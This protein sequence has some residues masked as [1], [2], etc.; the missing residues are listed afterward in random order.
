[1][2]RLKTYFPDIVGLYIGSALSL[3]LSASCAAG[4]PI[5]TDVVRGEKSAAIDA[6]FSGFNEAT[7][8]CAVAVDYQG[9]IV[10]MDGYGM[11][12]L[13]QAVPIKS[14]SVFYAGSVSKQVVAMSVMLLDQ[15]GKVDLDAKL[16][17]YLAE[18]PD[19]ANQVTVRQV[20][21][22]TSGI[23]DFF[24]LLR[25]AG[26]FDGMVITENM[27]TEILARQEGLNFTPGEQYAYSNSAYFLISQIVQQVEGE[28]LDKFS[29][30]NI[31]KPLGMENSH[32]QHN[33]RRLVPNK[34]HGYM[35]SL[36][37]D[38]ESGYMQADATLD[39]VGSGGMYTTVYD[40]IL[41]DR[42]F[43][44]NVL[45]SGQDI[46]QEMQTSGV[47]NAGGETGYGIGLKLKPY[48]GLKQISH[49][50]S[51]AGYRARLQRFPDHKFTVAILCNTAAAKPTKL[52]NQITDIF[53]K[54]YLQAKKPQQKKKP[55]PSATAFQR[56]SYEHALYAGR[57]YSREVDN[58]ITLEIAEH[59]LHI[60]GMDG[61]HDRIL[62]SASDNVYRHP[63]KNFELV[64]ERQPDGKV[65]AFTFNGAR[66]AGIRFT[67]LH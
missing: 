57:Y 29:Q 30:E 11:A 28:N 38:L 5:A 16:S 67:K 23:R 19:Y 24:E 34:A 10:H 20:L 53:L 49:S 48:R 42:N 2:K 62:Y 43:Y 63:I 52:A 27:I 22:H 65:L 41:W 33:H 1:M 58:T 32:F 56:S 66:A 51:L 8:G 54:E 26:R 61:L 64:F 15:D 7:P 35:P 36:E 55:K 40:L 59:G 12:D 25:L 47:L 6:L 37:V 4:R 45:G 31:F 46:A 50:G 18:Q 39:V 14:N 60:T 44:D 9:V 17:T 13:E 21:H 3:L